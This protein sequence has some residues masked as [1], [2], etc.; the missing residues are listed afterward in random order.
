MSSTSS[1]PA[2]WAAVATSAPSGRSTNP[3]IVKLDGWTRRTSVGRRPAPGPISASA[4][5]MSCTRVRFVVPTSTRRAPA[6]RI[7]SGIRTPPP[8]STSSPLL[9]MTRPPRPARPT[10][11]ARAAALLFVTS[12]S[13]APVRATRCSSAARKRGP[14]R[15]VARSSSRSGAP[16]AAAAAASIAALGQ[17]ARPR[18]VWRMTPVALIATGGSARPGSAKPSRRS[19]RSAAS[20]AT[21]RGATP[22][23]RRLRSAATTARAAA[24]S[25]P[26]SRP[27]ARGRAAAST[28]SMLGGRRSFA[29]AEAYMAAPAE[30]RRPS[31]ACRRAGTRIV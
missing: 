25:A 17:A 18:F 2:A 19:R 11:R 27:P 9:T 20:S 24:V 13:C 26:G 23:C 30:R 7:T 5:A 15:P 16:A 28:R 12:A 10:A 6:R 29:T 21:V 4:S 8:I 1:A 22:A 3:A 31:G 14:R